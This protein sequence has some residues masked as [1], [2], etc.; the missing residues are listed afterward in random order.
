MLIMAKQDK[1]KVNKEVWTI[2]VVSAAAATT[3]FLFALMLVNSFV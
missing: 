1:T 3:L 2:F